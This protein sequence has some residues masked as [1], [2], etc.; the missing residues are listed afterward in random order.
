[1]AQLTVAKGTAYEVTVEIKP[2]VGRKARKLL[3]PLVAFVMDITSGSTDPAAMLAKALT[4]AH[5]E[6]VYVPLALNMQD[7]DGQKWLDENGTPMEIFAAFMEA[8]KII[9]GDV[10]RGDVKDALGKSSGE[11]EVP[12]SSL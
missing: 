11:E 1:M 5:Y 12:V 6:D 3:S 2:P 8:I 10:E 4:N 7:K 9:M